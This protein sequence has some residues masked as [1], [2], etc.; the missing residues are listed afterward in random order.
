MLYLETSNSNSSR[1]KSA[2]SSIYKSSLIRRRSSSASRTYT[3]IREDRLA[4]TFSTDRAAKARVLARTLT[5]VRLLQLAVLAISLS[6]N[7]LNRIM[8]YT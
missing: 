1:I 4:I 6:H 7:P 5:T 3:G 8:S 2:I